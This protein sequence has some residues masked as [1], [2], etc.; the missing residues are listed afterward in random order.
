MSEL[1]K[2][3]L[4]GRWVIISA[5]RSKRGSDWSDSVIQP[6]SNTFCPFCEGNEDRTPPEITAIRPPGSLANTPGWEIR[7]VPNK[8]PALDVNADLDFQEN[9]LYKQ[10][11][12][13]GAHEVI[14]ETPKHVMQLAEL[15]QNHIRNLLRIY[16]SRIFELSQDQRFRYILV[17][18]N[19]GYAAGASLEH[20]HTQLIAT[21]IIPKRVHEEIQGFRHY[22]QTQKKCVLCDTITQ[23]M[24][25]QKRVVTQNQSFIAIEPF[26][27]CFPFETWIIP[28][29]H[30]QYFEQMDEQYLLDLSAILKEVLQ[31]LKKGLKQSPY[32]FILHTSPHSVGSKFLF[33]WHLEIV[34]KLTKVAGFEWGS[35]FYINPVPP[36]NAAEWL[37]NQ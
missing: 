14:I 7:V 5:E 33:H 24:K 16:Q 36:E 29:A 6:K 30:W 35:G 3:P 34:P 23:E 28:F 37:R 25:Y 4:T 12:G 17:F 22:F 13:V 19:S 8:F 26:A 20:S 21:P 11:N 18:K 9:G 27:S 32:N 2:D 1:R 10:I 15:P 31:R